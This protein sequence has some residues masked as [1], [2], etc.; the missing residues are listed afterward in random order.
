MTT[1]DRDKD[2]TVQNI[3]ERPI[4]AELILCTYTL[5]ENIVNQAREINDQNLGMVEVADYWAK[6]IAEGTD[7]MGSVRGTYEKTRRKASQLREFIDFQQPTKAKKLQFLKQT[8]NNRSKQFYTLD[9]LMQTNTIHPSERE[10]YKFP[11]YAQDFPYR[12]IHQYRR[13]RRADKSEYLDTTEYITGV[14]DQGA[15]VT[16]CLDPGPNKYLKPQIFHEKRN[17]DGTPLI[18]GANIANTETELVSVIRSNPNREVAGTVE[19][20]TPWNKDVV[21]SALRFSHGEPGDFAN[22]SSLTIV[23]ENHPKSYGI[24]DPEE[25]VNVDFDTLWKKYGTQ[26][27]VNTAGTVGGVPYR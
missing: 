13:I 16:I 9:G 23:K 26:P 22:G 21:M 27:N 12:T 24:T 1:K 19:Y 10:L 18:P 7:S 17:I 14:S 25:F 8:Y 2:N 4:S 15:V 5:T 11:P 3:Y 20:L 6:G